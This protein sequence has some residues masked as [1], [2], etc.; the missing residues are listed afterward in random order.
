MTRK[1]RQKNRCAACGRYVGRQYAGYEH[2][3]WFRHG[4]LV[5]ERCFRRKAGPKSK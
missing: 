5:C 4:A 1:P 2:D 3:S